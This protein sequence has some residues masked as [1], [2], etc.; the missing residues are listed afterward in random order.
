AGKLELKLSCFNFKNEIQKLVDSFSGMVIEK[1][2][3]I[4]LSIS[5][6][7]PD[8]ILLDR[9]KLSQILFNIIGNAV[10][11]T[12]EGGIIE[13]KISGEVIISD[14]LIL[15]IA[16][17][18]T[19]KGIPSSQISKLTPPFT[20]V[21][22][23]DSREHKG[24]GLGLAIAS[25]LIELMGGVLQIDSE[26]GHGSEFSF[27]LMACVPDHDTGKEAEDKQQQPQGNHFKN[28]AEPFPA[29]ILLVEDNEINLKF[30]SIV[31]DQ[32]GYQPDI[33]KNGLEAVQMVQE[34]MYDLIFMDQQM[35]KM[36]GSE[37]TKA[38]RKLENGKSPKIIGL[39]AH[40]LSMD[41][42][43]IYLREMD[44]YLSKPVKIE[45]IAEKI[46]QCYETSN[47]N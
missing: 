42:E 34:N 44:G 10:K 9:K 8:L 28:F 30:M 18:D 29:R 2:I 37:A 1:N 12:Y 43:K 33:A 20:Q 15:Y 46:K 45:E 40:V 31:L 3:R 32:M 16:V 22:S 25:K 47:K 13:I 17:K 4:I 26:E 41:V 24:T 19:G 5:D 7:I 36:D 38:I 27:T 14:N 11:F 21:D 23:S 39:S 35:P 6:K